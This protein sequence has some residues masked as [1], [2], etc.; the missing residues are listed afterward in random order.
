[1][2]TSCDHRDN[3]Q[4]DRDTRCIVPIE[5]SCKCTHCYKVPQSADDSG[6]KQQLIGVDILDNVRD[7]R[8]LIGW[9]SLPFTNQ[10]PLSDIH[11][12]DEPK[13]EKRKYPIP[14]RETVANR[15]RYLAERR[16]KPT[17]ITASDVNNRRCVA[18]NVS[19]TGDRLP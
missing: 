9:Q 19:A 17:A 1:M 5:D 12:S 3:E 13:I 8:L 16:Y 6:H 2:S 15:P 11:D 4:H 14:A 10:Q 7:A 18:T